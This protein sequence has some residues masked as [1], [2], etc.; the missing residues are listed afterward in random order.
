[1][2]SAEEAVRQAVLS[3]YDALDKLLLG[4]G[5]EGMLDR[6]WHDAYVSTVHPFGHWAYGWDEVWATWQESAAVFGMYR[7]HRDRTD[8][9]GGFHDARIEVIGDAAL[10][11]GV[12]KST[13]YLPKGPTH[14]KVNCTEV[15]RRREGVWKMVHHHSDQAPPDYQAAIAGLVN[16]S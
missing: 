4:K 8:G 1:M 3:F 13:L 11:V 6:W 15:L 2:P 5:P 12:Y 9:I 7:G 14:L 10:V 16:A